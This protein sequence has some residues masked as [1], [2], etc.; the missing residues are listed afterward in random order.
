MFPLSWQGFQQER[1][2]KKKR[3]VSP[4]LNTL[5]KIPLIPPFSKGE[6]QQ[7][8]RYLIASPFGKGRVR[9][10][11]WAVWVGID[12]TGGRGLE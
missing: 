1:G 3:G 7:G 5:I 9:E 12:N 8:K 4:L 6:T 11:F 10:G 2:K